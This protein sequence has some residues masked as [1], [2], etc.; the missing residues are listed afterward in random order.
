MKKRLARLLTLAV[1]GG[2]ALLAAGWEPNSASQPL[3]TSVAEAQVYAGEAMS[4][5]FGDYPHGITCT[6][7]M[8]DGAPW[9]ECSVAL[10][11]S[12]PRLFFVK[13]G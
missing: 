1:V 12:E 4:Y 10:R 2:I 5:H 13:Q 7:T 8:L 6:E 9:Y 11:G 3:P